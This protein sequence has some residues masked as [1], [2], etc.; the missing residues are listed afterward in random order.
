MAADQA[1]RNRDV[2]RNPGGCA[3]NGETIVIGIPGHIR[4]DYIAA[5]IN[6]HHVIILIGMIPN[7]DAFYSET[8]T[9]QIMLHPEG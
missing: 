2:L 8:I 7:A 4:D 3:F 9:A 5:T 6:I 1:I